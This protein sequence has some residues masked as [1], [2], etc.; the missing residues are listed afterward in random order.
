MKTNKNYNNTNKNSKKY[1]KPIKTKIKSINHLFQPIDQ[2]SKD[3][4]IQKV[5]VVEDQQIRNI[6]NH[7]KNKSNLFIIMTNNK[8]INRL[9][10]PKNRR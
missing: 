3:K 5:L 7:H 10:K 2:P 1:N 6:N 8:L 9:S 4:F